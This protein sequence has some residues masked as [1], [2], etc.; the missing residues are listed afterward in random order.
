MLNRKIAIC[1]VFFLFFTKIAAQQLNYPLLFLQ[2]NYS[3]IIKLSDKAIASGGQADDYYWHAMARRKLAD[4][5]SVLPLLQKA[6]QLFPYDINIHRLLIDVLFDNGQYTD[7][8]NLIKKGIVPEDADLVKKMIVIYEFYNNL[9]EAIMLLQ[10]NLQH[11]S[12]NVYYR[13]HLADNYNKLG[14]DSAAISNYSLIYRQNHSNMVAIKRLCELNLKK[15]PDTVIYF[16]N[17][18]L[19]YDSLN[20][21]FLRLKAL[22]YIQKKTFIPALPLLKTLYSIGDSSLTVLKNLGTLLYYVTEYKEA[23]DYMV[24]A[25]KLDSLNPELN[26]I[27]GLCLVNTNQKRLGIS[28]F[29][30]AIALMIPNPVSLSVIYEQIALTYRELGDYSLSLTYYENAYSSNPDNKLILISIASIYEKNLK[31]KETAYEKYQMFLDEL[32]KMKMPDDTYKAH[33]LLYQKGEAEKALKRL[34]EELFFENKLN[35]D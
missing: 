4:D 17:E 14:N 32:S 11:D 34:K 5:A 6:A 13:M 16:C 28:Y 29:F 22:A 30:K 33:E 12:L 23:R 15:N 31:N 3:E 20:A 24:K 7:V 10:K 35:P 2:Q 25:L 18:A 8:L 1:F 19:Q 26:Y 9:N 21:A 27:Y